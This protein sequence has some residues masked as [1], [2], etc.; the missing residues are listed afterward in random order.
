M[1]I[2]FQGL[3]CIKRTP[4]ST[5]Y[6]LAISHNHRKSKKVHKLLASVKKH[7]DV[8]DSWTWATN[9]HMFFKHKFHRKKLDIQVQFKILRLLHQVYL[10][11]AWDFTN[12]LRSFW[13]YIAKLSKYRKWIH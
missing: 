8:D 7:V 4:K 12:L 9:V 1:G 3:D 6:N 2:Y 13:L 5:L 11:Q 10:S